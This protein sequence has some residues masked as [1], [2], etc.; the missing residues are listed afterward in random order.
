M[1]RTRD[2]IEGQL[3]GREALD[4]HGALKL[5]PSDAQPV[6]PQEYI[7]PWERLPREGDVH[8]R[9]FQHYLSSGYPEGP[10]GT[11]RARDIPALAEALHQDPLMLA[12]IARGHDWLQRAGAW[13]RIV[14]RRRTALDLTAVDAQRVAH[15]RIAEKMR[16][17]AEMELDKLLSR[18]MDA[19]A[20]CMT[21]R[22]V[23]QMVDMTVRLERLFAGEDR[24]AQGNGE[25]LASLDLE[26]LEAMHAL[27]EKAKG[28]AH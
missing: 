25:D 1:S 4:P 17:L 19:S 20:P 12:S 9:L 6:D 15:G 28:R 11:F 24:P 8:W 26:D 7:R 16:T 14:A 22:E 5:L 21:P 18:A 2:H 13:D 3:A 27:L 23:M 10:G